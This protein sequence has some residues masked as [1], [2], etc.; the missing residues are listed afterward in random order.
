VKAHPGYCEEIGVFGEMESPGDG[1]GC[2]RGGGGGPGSVRGRGKGQ[3]SVRVIE[4]SERKIF[5]SE[6]KRYVPRNVLFVVA[7]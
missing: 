5:K 4:Q 7:S 3:G 1:Q 2:V 6:Q